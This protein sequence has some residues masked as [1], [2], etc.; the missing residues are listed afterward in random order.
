MAVVTTVVG[1]M[2]SGSFPPETPVVA[3]WSGRVEMAFGVAFSA[4]AQCFDPGGGQNGRM[5]LVP[6][7]AAAARWSTVPVG[8]RARRTIIGPRRRTAW[9]RLLRGATGR[10]VLRG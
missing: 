4:V 9:R 5:A 7:A 2:V 10:R 3:W 8:S 6:A 1:F